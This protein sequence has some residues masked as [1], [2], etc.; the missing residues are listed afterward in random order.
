MQRRQLL[1]GI[2]SA[3]LTG[4][5]VPGSALYQVFDAY[6]Q[7][8]LG[9]REYPVTRAQIDAQ[10]LGVLGVQVEGGFKGFMVWDRR[11][12][13]DDHWQSG[14]GVRV[15]TAAGRIVSTRG[16]PLDQQTSV[17]VGGEEPWG[18]TLERDKEYRCE[19]LLRFADGSERAVEC[20]LRYDSRENIDLL[21]VRLEAARWQETLLAASY[22]RPWKQILWVAADGLVV[23]S[24]QHLGANQRVRLELLRPPVT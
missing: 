22:Q 10:P 16:F 15:V 17:L 12:G 2:G 13:D 11:E 8:D 1:L 23:R 20:R 4:C 9:K 19:R 18:Q 7:L 24:V 3:A 6:R 14:N 5:A 21:G